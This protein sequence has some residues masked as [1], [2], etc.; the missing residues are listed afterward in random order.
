M[1]V[2]K[3]DIPTIN[4]RREDIIPICDFYLSY[5]NKNKKYRLSFSNNS[6][7]KL[8]LYDWPGN[9]SQII[10]YIEKTMILNQNLNDEEDFLIENLPLDMGDYDEKQNEENNLELSL[11]E[12][13]NNFEKNYLLS[14]IKRFNG[15]I[16]NISNFT[17]MERTALYRKFKS[18]NIDIE[19]NK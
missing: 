8:N 18:L 3:I 11:K 2:I 1:A 13:R 14:Q 10:N 6:K 19:K 17:G 15:N 5:Y 7:N 12:A 4:L 9:I 16:K